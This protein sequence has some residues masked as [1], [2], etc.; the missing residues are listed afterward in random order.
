MRSNVTRRDIWKFA[1]EDTVYL[2]IVEKS[3]EG[4]AKAIA[5]EFGF[6]DDI[7]EELAQQIIENRKP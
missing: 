2:E 6:R 5:H 1:K 4:L 7:A 3:K